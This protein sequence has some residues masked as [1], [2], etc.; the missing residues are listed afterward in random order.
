MNHS[1]S[2]NDSHAAGGGMGK[3]NSQNIKEQD[4]NPFSSSQEALKFAG[5]SSAIA[6]LSEA[7][8]TVLKASAPANST[9]DSGPP[10][11]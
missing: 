7:L 8:E 2:E 9:H 3:T 4:A 10:E 1:H 6:T 11:P 5:G